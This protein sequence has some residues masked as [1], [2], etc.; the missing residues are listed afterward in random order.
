MGID[1]KLLLR[2]WR[3]NEGSK[4]RLWGLMIKKRERDKF[5]CCKE[6]RLRVG[7][8]RIRKYFVG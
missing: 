4:W 5:V 2:R 1:C 6:V 3:G 7:F 8:F